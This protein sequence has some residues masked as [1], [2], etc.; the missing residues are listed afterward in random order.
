MKN[1]IKGKVTKFGTKGYGFITDDNGDQYFVHQKNVFDQSRL[2]VGTRV[3]FNAEHSEKGKVA[4]SVTL[5]NNAK[6][7]KSKPKSKPK[8]LSDG[9][10]KSLFTLLFIAQIVV[11]YKVFG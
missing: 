4:M 6:T 7:S 5:E 2:T 10:V 1:K 8:P 9:I 3:I 11:A